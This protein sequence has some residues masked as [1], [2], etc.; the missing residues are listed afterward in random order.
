[1]TTNPFINAAAATLYIIL[2]ASFMYLGQTLFANTPDTIVAPIGML[3]L[4]VLSA[5][6]MAYLFLS[7]P[8]TMILGGQQREGVR[9]FLNTIAVF[10]AITIIILALLFIIK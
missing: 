9:L 2:V 10:A 4:F 1:M 3:S 5:A 8:V 6:V 7:R